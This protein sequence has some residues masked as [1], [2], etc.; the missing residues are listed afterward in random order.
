M[1]NEQLISHIRGEL[2]NH[3]DRSEIIKSL[4]SAGW[5]VE[6]INEALNICDKEVSGVA[7]QPTVSTYAQASEPTVASAKLPGV[8]ALIGSGISLVRER[9]KTIMSIVMISLLPGILLT[10][11]DLTLS[12][13]GGAISE[14]FNNL[15]PSII[16]VIGAVILLILII[17]ASALIYL[18]STVAL[19][20]AVVAPE[21]IGAHEAFS[22]A[23]HKLGSFVWVSI[24]NAFTVWGAIFVPISL[25]VATFGI[26]FVTKMDSIISGALSV[27]SA[28][29]S[30]KILGPIAIVLFF[31]CILFVVLPFSIRIM[32]STWLVV[33]DRA[34]GVSALVMSNKMVRGR[35]WALLWRCVCIFLVAYVAILIIAFTSGFVSVLFPAISLLFGWI[36]QVLLVP[37]GIAVT[38]VLYHAVL[39]EEAMQ[40]SIKDR[41]WWVVTLAILGLVGI[42]AVIAA[43]VYTIA[44]TKNELR[45]HAPSVDSALATTS[46]PVLRTEPYVNTKLGYS[47]NPPNGWIDKRNDGA[48]LNPSPDYEGDKSYFANISANVDSSEGFVD[49]ER[50]FAG[51]KSYITAKGLRVVSS[52]SVTVGDHPAILSITQITKNGLE[53]QSMDLFVLVDQQIYSVEAF[54]LASK[55]D[56]YKDLFEA[57]LLSFK[58][59]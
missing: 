46:A 25:L 20:C 13:Q 28:I 45:S 58:I 49:V 23:R 26:V 4:L 11:A 57:S 5:H 14:F 18:L 54:T 3:V 7:N 2:A 27:D 34:R 30:F 55:W 52:R 1:P 12:L 47:F 44:M 17:V 59:I 48:F 51:Y 36:I 35:T 39:S 22:R 15:T 41:K 9:T 42:L 40:P 33:E 8:F 43:T 32:F 21:D 24:L 53:Y 19:I 31:I 56:K 50:W 6:D 10:V 37:M 16:V 29:Q 38:A